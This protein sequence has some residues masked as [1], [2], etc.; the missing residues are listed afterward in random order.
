MGILITRNIK[1]MDDAPQR[2][3]EHFCV[4]NKLCRLAGV[5]MHPEDVMINHMLLT[6]ASS[7]C[8]TLHPRHP[9]RGQE[10]QGEDDV[11]H[12]KMQQPPEEAHQN[13]ETS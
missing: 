8:K 7:I 3:R 10:E 12:P 2:N 6:T 13:S 9:A 5:Q 11:Y 1:F 4:I